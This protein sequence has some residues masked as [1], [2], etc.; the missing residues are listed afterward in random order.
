MKFCYVDESR[1]GDEPYAVMVGIV[2][3]A[4]RMR[5]TKADWDGLLKHLGRIVGRSIEEIHTRDFYAG[6]GPW[7][8][9]NGSQRAVIIGSVMDWIGNRKHLFVY[10]A[11]NKD[12][13]LS[14]FIK[15]N[16]HGDIKTIWRFLGMH[17]VLAIQKY[18]QRSKN[19]KGNTILIFDNEEREQNHFTDLIL[20]PPDWTETYYKRTRKQD[21][22]DQIIDIPYFA[23]SKHVPLLQVADFVAYFLRR[24]AELVGGD[25]ERYSG[26]NKQVQR[27]V[28]TAL[29]RAVPKSVVYP[30]KGRC[31]CAD[32]FYTYAP[33]AIRD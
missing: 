11:V 10:S 14:E 32:L 17:L 9:I 6:N 4:M 28:S 16:R 1:T 2:V 12:K 23:D 21:E 7:R 3:D 25:T 27:W 29:K 30:K 5:P 19:N 33:E 31:A 20:N 15:D 13:F 8:E 26:E 18:H 24:Y 22:I